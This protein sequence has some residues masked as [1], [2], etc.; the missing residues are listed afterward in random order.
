MSV[1]V[2]VRGCTWSDLLRL[3]PPPPPSP[4]K[5]VHYSK[6]VCA[7][8][9]GLNC[10]NSRTKSTSA[11][12]YFSVD[13]NLVYGE[14]MIRINRTYWATHYRTTHSYTYKK[15]RLSRTTVTHWKRRKR[16]KTSLNKINW[17]KKSKNHKNAR[18]LAVRGE[19]V[20]VGMA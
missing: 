7:A 11:R 14:L 3:S 5:S 4:E 1:C 8:P 20:G 13:E 2:C 12:F 15:T 19:R 18:L 17:K 9:D 10:L 6:N 16:T